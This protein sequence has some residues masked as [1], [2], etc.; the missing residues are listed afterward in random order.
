M[1]RITRGLVLLPI[2]IALLSGCKGNSGSGSTSSVVSNPTEDE[3]V[4]DVDPLPE[5]TTPTIAFAQHP[6]SQTVYLGETLVLSVVPLGD[7]TNAFFHWYKESSANL[8]STTDVPW[9]E[10]ED[11]QLDD[12]GEY[13]VV[14]EN[15]SGK[16]A[17]RSA[18]IDVK[19]YDAILSWTW[20]ET[21]VNGELIAMDEINYG[22]ILYVQSD[23]ELTE[24]QF[25][26]HPE[27]QTQDVF[28]ESY[29]DAKFVFPDLE[30]GRWE[31]RMTVVDTNGY[32]SDLSNPASKIIQ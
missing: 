30:S 20:P 23:S 3:I 14:A 17:S 22:L 16:V 24:E 9:I 32:S 27:L 7:Y 11:I 1:A 6:E 8:I 25:L 10:I 18:I 13:Y 19:N 28:V 5:V 26:N 29:P 31:F 2:G 12:S 15:E 4:L 21:R